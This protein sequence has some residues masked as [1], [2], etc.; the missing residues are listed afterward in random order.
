[1]TCKKN[2]APANVKRSLLGGLL[3][4][5]FIHSIFGK[6]GWLN[7]NFRIS[8]RHRTLPNFNTKNSEQ[9]VLRGQNGYVN[10]KYSFDTVD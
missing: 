6:T 7:K 2:V 8:C 4:A 5:G 9:L 1:M 10:Y 3:G